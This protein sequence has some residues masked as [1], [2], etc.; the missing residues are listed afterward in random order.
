MTAF[1][2][3]HNFDARLSLNVNV[4]NVFH[5]GTMES[6]VENEVLRLNSLTTGQ[7]RVVQIGLRYQWG[8]VTGDD[9]IRNGGRGNFRGGP[10]GRGGEG[11]SGNGGFG[12]GGGRGF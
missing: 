11:G 10:E 1:T 3:R 8:G 5:T 2:W 7:P 6:D 4:A 9:R 12:N